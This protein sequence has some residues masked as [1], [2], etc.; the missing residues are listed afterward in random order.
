MRQLSKTQFLAL[1]AFLRCPMHP[2]ALRQE[3]IE[4]T[5]NRYY[6]SQ[7][8]LQRVIMK[9]EEL[10][11]IEESGNSQ[12]WLRAKRS[13][14]YELTAKGRKLIDR[15]LVMYFE[16]ISQAKLSIQRREIIIKKKSRFD[17]EES[18]LAQIP[19]QNY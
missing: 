8:T 2:Y 19:L 4:M 14:P 9:L 13:V 17:Q 1:A 7:S 12:Y 6:P 10:G 3:I 5:G 11:F 16:V 15:E 18:W